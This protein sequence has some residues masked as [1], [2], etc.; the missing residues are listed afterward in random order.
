M[1][2]FWD[3]EPCKPRGLLI[4]VMIEAVR[5]S[6]TSVYFYETICNIPED[7]NLYSCRRENLKT[8]KNT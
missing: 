8:H 5:I 4:S 3:T 2:S 1:T 7:C 6:E